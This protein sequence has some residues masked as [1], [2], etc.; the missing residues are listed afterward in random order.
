MGLRRR[1]KI[2]LG[3]SLALLLV[4]AGLW[5][6]RAWLIGQFAERY[7]RQHGVTAQVE[8]GALGLSGASG[9]FA[10][11]PRDAPE[12]AVE[13][14]EL[15][16]DPLRWSPYLV[17]VRLENPL[18]RARVDEKGRVS[19]GSLQ[20]WLESLQQS[21]EKSPYVSDD[22]VI[23]FSGLRALLATPAG[24]ME[25][26]G[27]ARV[28]KNLPEELALSL[29]P[30]NFNWRGQRVAA[31]TVM[32]NLSR[33]GALAV[34]LAGDFANEE[35]S[36]DGVA[37]ALD[38]QGLRF[39]PD[40]RADGGAVSLRAEAGSVMI[41]GAGASGIT[42]RIAMPGL[43]VAGN[44]LETAKLDAAITA[45]AAEAGAQA[46]DI[47][48]TLAARDMRASATDVTGEGDVVLTANAT[49]PPELARAIRAFPAFQMEPPLAAAIA[50]NLGRVA[51]SAKAHA[52]R[53][54]GKMEAR[55]S[56][57]LTLRGSGGGVLQIASL[58]VSGA[59]DALEG[60]LNASL[61]GGGLPSLTLA[62]NRFTFDGKTFTAA[63]V[64]DGQLDFSA[65]RG[66]RASLHGQAVY[67]DGDFRFTQSGCHAAGLAM[68]GPLARDVRAQVCPAGRPLF[69]FGPKGWRF[70]VLARG[71][72]GFL[73]LAN[74]ELSDGAALLSFNGT[75]GLS[76]AV[77]LRAAKL[78]D[79]ASPLRFNP[80]EGTGE[81]TLANG[82]WRGRVNALD[83]T[84][85]QLGV[86]TF[87]HDMAKGQGSAHVD[88]PLVFAE[89]KLQPEQLSPLMALLKQAA[90]RAAF[91]GDFGWNSTGLTAQ[92]G[93]LAVR[94]FS[95]LTPMG[96]ATA[97][98]TTLEL[99]SLLPPAT[100]DG[101]ELTIGNI[102]WTIPMSDV[103]ARFSFSTTSLRIERLGLAFATG[104]V[105]LTPFGFNP[106][107]P[108]DFSSTAALTGISLEPLIAASNLSGKAALLGKVSG[109]VPFTV[110]ADGFRIKDGRLTSDGPG[111]LELSRSL[112][113]ESAQSVNAVQDFAYQALENLAFDSL[114]ADI[115]SVG[116]GRLQIVFHIK[117]RSDP[118][119]PQVADVAVSDIINGTALQ[120]PVPLPSG[121]PIDL[122]LDASLNFDELLKSYAEAWS[123]SLEGLGAR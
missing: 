115:N 10:L 114:T 120:K 85:A 110:G 64:L 42:A 50:R 68:L 2:I 23:A 122:T 48:L 91:K 98:D 36:A 72:T 4:L 47:A 82:Q 104:R 100:K 121:T 109:I 12:A 20:G 35:A 57:P 111:R 117:G 21:N 24:P 38:M 49:L 29:K 9:R 63:T 99:I 112:W 87:Q 8:I 61:R 106:S 31:R 69:T 6:A 62:L 28:V 7:F 16:F 41:G 34:R 15:F 5:L 75:G 74:A 44:M 60:N 32:L 89:D 40:G 118:P 83:G 46:G 105:A 45:K 86:A 102:A 19:L 79:K 93:T 39:T 26:N 51:I 59:P 22:L 116:Q 56:E 96:R 52:R 13:K 53:R 73:P 33:D 108:G 27:S 113:G 88:A 14:I 1:G 123:K 70:E 90:G 11:G 25:V 43:R 81:I 58:S 67:A 30:G 18:V 3:V 71:A 78:S 119:R 54:D 65:L 94:D 17:E 84:G 66:I 103:A 37:L 92:G 97:V 80:L 55:L 101:Q 95:F 107:A 77:T 76:G